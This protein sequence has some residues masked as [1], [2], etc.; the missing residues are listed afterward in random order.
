M[1]SSLEEKIGQRLLLAFDCKGLLTQEIQDAIQRY[2]PGG[3]TLFRSLNIENPN[4]VRQL[5]GAFQDVAHQIGLPR[6]LIAADQEGG[7]LMALGEGMTQLPGNM[8]LGATRD[9]SLARRAGEVLGRE[10]AALG[11]NVNYAPCVDVN[12]NPQNP[13][14]GTRSFGEDPKTVAQLSAAM[15]EGIQSQGVAAT[16]KH[17]PGHGDTS[18]DSHRGLPVVPHSL[19]R[20]RSVEFPPFDAAIRAGAKVIMTAHLALPVID[21]VN[22]PPAT[23]SASVLKGLL[24][25]EL[26]FG[27]VIVTD[28]MDMHAISQGDRLGESAVRAAQAGADLL[29]ITSSP[30]D[31]Q[32]VHSNLLQAAKNGLLADN[33]LNASVERTSSLKRWLADQPPAP[34]INV[35]GCAEHQQVA[36]EIAAR[37]ITL[38]RNQAGLLPLRLESSQRVAVIIPRPADLTPADTSSYIIPSLASALREFHPDMDEFIISHSPTDAEIASLLEQ[39]PHYNLIVLATINAFTN[40][41]QQAM[42]RE[43]IKR[44][45]PTLVVAL[46]LPYDLAMLEEVSTF[47]CTYS[48]LEPSM[49]ALASSLFGKTKFQGQLPVSIPSLFP[50]GYGEAL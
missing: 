33:E 10:L 28:A 42:T 7:Q 23:L 11:I 45:I 30:T 44:G 18:S 2:R 34:D 21:G 20:L 29:L 6:L 31:Q 36:D 3:I 12:V 43:I 41:G 4:Q 9:S 50:A 40:T 5:T 22:A 39:I 48:I 26:G 8:A 27:G 16:A 19:N 17:F 32:L 38:V 14:V 35:L 13:V 1:A 46:R 24:R 15:I 37:S 49:H 47:V 25:G